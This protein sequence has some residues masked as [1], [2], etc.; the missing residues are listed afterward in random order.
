MS[1]LDTPVLFLATVDPAR[2]R[3][4]Y[5]DVLGLAFVADEPPAL[6]FQVGDSM[7]RIQK[8]ERVH[9]APYTALGWSVS[10]IHA[11]VRRLTAAGVKFERY[12]GMD[13]DVDGIWQSP[14]GALVAWFPDPDGN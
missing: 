7:L 10:D 13:Q 12:E 2:S 9:T 5:E 6:V 8:V 14:S 1:D 4:F 3:E 11:T